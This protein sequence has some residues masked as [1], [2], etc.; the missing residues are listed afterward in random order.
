MGTASL[1][2]LVLLTWKNNSRRRQTWRGNLEL[3][4]LCT[5]TLPPS[6][7]PSLPF[8]RFKAAVSQCRSSL[9]SLGYPSFT[10]EDF[11]DTVCYHSRIITLLLL[12]FY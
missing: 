2:L 6:L 10:L 5:C 7:P 4:L 11:H 8:P 9:L 1:E 3:S 12:L